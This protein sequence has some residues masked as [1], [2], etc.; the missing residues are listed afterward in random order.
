MD[1]LSTGLVAQTLQRLF[2]EAE[3]ADRALME[4]Y[5]NAENPD[6]LAE[7]FAEHFA[8]ERR[9]VRGFYRGYV[10]NFLNVTP[11]YGRFLYQCARARK[12]TR[13]IEFGTSMGIST[14]YLAAALHDMGGGKLIGTE[15]EASKAARARATLRRR[16][17]RIWSTSGSATRGKRSSMSAA[18]SI[19]F[20]STEHSAFIFRCSSCLSRI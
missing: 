17:S 6:Q 10:D 19:W 1:S 9:D 7:D 18:I 3:Q 4:Q 20:C 15:L 16:G 2:T 12:A 11:E 14:I 13:I 5:S 8:E